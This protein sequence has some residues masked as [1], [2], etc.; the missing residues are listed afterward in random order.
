MPARVKVPTMVVKAEL[1]EATPSA[2]SEASPVMVRCA[3]IQIRMRNTG[4]ATT[5]HLGHGSFEYQQRW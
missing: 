2:T 1:G 5:E 3:R 4:Y